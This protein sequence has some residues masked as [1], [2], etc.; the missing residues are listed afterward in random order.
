[1]ILPLSLRDSFNSVTGV[2]FDGEEF[3]GS[4]ILSFD[5]QISGMLVL[6]WSMFLSSFSSF[7]VFLVITNSFL[8]VQQ[9]PAL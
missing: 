5:K 4:A 7:K 3:W 8:L 2:W 9:S 6:L 1:M